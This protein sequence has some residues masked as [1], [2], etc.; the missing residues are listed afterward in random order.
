M[1]E[2]PL[3]K[4]STD[5]VHISFDRRTVNQIKRTLKYFNKQN[6]DIM[7]ISPVLFDPKYR[8]NREDII[9]RENIRNMLH[10][11]I[12]EPFFNF[13]EC[14]ELSFVELLVKYINQTDSMVIFDE[15]YEEL[16]VRINKK[17]YNWVTPKSFYY[18]S[19]ERVRDAFNSLRRDI[20]LTQLLT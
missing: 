17:S 2:L 6:L 14:N 5:Q 10:N 8:R 15:E 12:Y 13:F 7:L 20:K 19:P 4:F 16:L 9:I 11:W 18:E 1:V 3:F